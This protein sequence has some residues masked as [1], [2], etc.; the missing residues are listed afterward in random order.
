MIDFEKIKVVKP[1]FGHQMIR[2]ESLKIYENYGW[3]LELEPP[4]TPKEVLKPILKPLE[5]A[6]GTPK[7]VPGILEFEQPAKRTRKSKQK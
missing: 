6:D 3:S 1:G 7:K 4:E 5:N 2:R